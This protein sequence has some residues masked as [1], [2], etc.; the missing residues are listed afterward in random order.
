MIRV[1]EIDLDRLR[2]TT[3]FSPLAQEEVDA[4]VDRAEVT[5]H[6]AGEV[7]TEQ[8]VIGHR[9][10][11]LLEGAADVERDGRTVAAIGGGDF[12]G[13]LGLL[14]GGASTATV[15]CTASTRCL[16]LEREAFWAVLQAQPEIALRILEVLS[17][18]LVRELRT[19]ATSNLGDE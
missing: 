15:R 8:G 13:E 9:F 4:F 11:L 10:H 16:T 5:E 2:R 14:G 1:T 18:R 19:G 3:L 12:V 17:R 6:A 7:L